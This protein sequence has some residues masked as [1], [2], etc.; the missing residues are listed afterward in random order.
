VLWRLRRLV[1]VNIY[2]IQ[3]TGKSL[4]AVGLMF[5]P[6]LAGI[7]CYSNMHSCVLSKYTS[8][9][10]L[11]KFTEEDF[12]L[13]NCVFL[14]D[15]AD[16][17]MDSRSSG[18]KA[19]KIYSYYFKQARKQNVFWITTTQLESALELRLRNLSEYRIK[20]D[21]VN[22]MF[23]FEIWRQY[24]DH[25]INVL[26]WNENDVLPVL[27]KLYDTNEVITPLSLDTRNIDWQLVK[28]YYAKANQSSRA[29]THLVASEY[30]QFTKEAVMASFDLL[31]NGEDDLARKVLSS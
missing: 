23:V 17:V 7:P 2:G 28:T 3:G 30:P 9:T 21:K 19:N 15:E 18:S 16:T 26:I 20:C 31:K 8:P 24:G 22:D 27:G 10:E 12:E 4:F 1:G 13:R 11:I 5:L 6:Y 29:F 14:T 25:P